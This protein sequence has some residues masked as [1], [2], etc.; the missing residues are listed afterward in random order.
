MLPSL[1]PV[2]ATIPPVSRIQGRRGRGRVPIRL[3]YVPFA[4]SIG[5]RIVAR[6]F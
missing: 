2:M 4:G 5:T 1:C 6:L 3:V